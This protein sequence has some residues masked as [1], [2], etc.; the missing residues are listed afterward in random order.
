MRFRIDGPLAD[1][2]IFALEDQ[3]RRWAFDARQG[4]LVPAPEPGVSNPR[5]AD[6]EAASDPLVWALPPWSPADGFE[7]MRDFAEL[8]GQPQESAE[9]TRI[10]DQGSGV[11]KAFRQRVKADSRLYRRWL[12]FK[13]RRFDEI[14]RAW[15]EER[16]EFWDL[17][18]RA[19]GLESEG[20]G[21][22][23][24]EELLLGDFSLHRASAR[25][26]QP[27]SQDW[28]AGAPNWEADLAEALAPEPLYPLAPAPDDLVWRAEEP[29]GALAGLL[30]VSRRLAGPRPRW[31][32]ERWYVSPERRGLG[33]GRLL[34]ETVLAAAAEDNAWV[35]APWPRWPRSVE[36]LLRRLGGRETRA[37]WCWEEPL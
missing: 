34:L 5:G 11:F 1:R 3:G 16:A 7:L 30:W 14:L 36:D 32:L 19:G 12:R 23:A 33:L 31:L 15:A 18:H 10:L 21:A 24:S 13:R 6:T 2:L 9:L 20:E 28:L 35:Q 25:D 4:D 26:F 8:P 27:R 17:S 29:G 37:G 22:E